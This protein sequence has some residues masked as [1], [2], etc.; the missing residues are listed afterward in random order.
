M[1][2]ITLKANISECVVESWQVN[3]GE[4]NARV[5]NV[6]MCEDLRSCDKQFVTFELADGKVYESLVVDGEAK[7]PIFEEPQF[8]KIGV[9]AENI[10]GD[11]CEKR[12]SAHPANHYVNSGSFKNKADEQPKPTPG[13]YSELLEKI[14][15]VDGSGGVV[16][17]TFN[18]ESKNAQSGIAVAEALKNISNDEPITTERIADD[19]VTIDKVEPDFFRE[20]LNLRTTDD[21]KLVG[22][23]K[24]P[25]KTLNITATLKNKATEITQ[26]ATDEAIP[27]AK[28]VYDLYK[29][30][31]A[32]DGGVVDILTTV[33]PAEVHT[34]EQVYGAKALDE[35]FVAIDEMLQEK[36]AELV[37]GENIKN[38]NG[39][40]ILGSGN[41]VI[42]GGAEVPENVETTDNK[43]TVINEKSTD[44]Q[45]SSAKAVY[46]YVNK[47]I[48]GIENGSY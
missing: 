45:Y 8:I 25:S 36:Q 19:A 22:T 10:N 21:I 16:D 17:Q 24:Y 43:V 41:L 1:E 38:I 47:V 11:E 9:Y 6:E 5:M 20:G 14:E 26:D 35:T 3:T 33:E 40:S 15:G 39:Q 46:D 48:G 28:A 18:P 44:A 31:E 23:R 29:S 30:I 13:D 2:Q 34:N 12:Y 4:V 42:E 7:I 32:S 37:S 27:T